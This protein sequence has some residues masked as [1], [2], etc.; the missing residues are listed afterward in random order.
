[1]LCGVGCCSIFK[2]NYY[3]STTT[4]TTLRKRE[5]RREDERMNEFEIVLIYLFYFY[6][7]NYHII[8]FFF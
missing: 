3:I 6:S 4:D 2:D 8:E 5:N 7:L 1:M